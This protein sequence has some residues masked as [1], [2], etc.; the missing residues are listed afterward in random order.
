[1]SGDGHEE[2]SPVGQE[3]AYLRCRVCGAKVWSWEWDESQEQYVDLGIDNLRDHYVL[4]HPEELHDIDLF[5][6]EEFEVYDFLDPWMPEDTGGLL[7][8]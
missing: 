1:M 7:E 2:S 4:F 5:L 8:C 6:Q 3:Q